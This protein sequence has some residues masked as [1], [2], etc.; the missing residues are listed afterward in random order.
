[1]LDGESNKLSQ[2]K[3]P[4]ADKVI[5]RGNGT[6]EFILFPISFINKT[7]KGHGEYFIKN[8]SPFGYRDW[9]LRDV[10]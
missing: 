10:V 9:K 3:K 4:T 5:G 2:K 6:D 7:N 1:M 8:K